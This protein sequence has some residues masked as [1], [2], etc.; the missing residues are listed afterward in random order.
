[1]VVGI[2]TLEDVLQE[3]LDQ[4]RA[5]ADP[6][7]KV[8]YFLVIGSTLHIHLHAPHTTRASARASTYTLAQTRT[9]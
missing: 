7:T 6:H 1:M 3:I 5:K 2:L 8:V 9:M 4:V